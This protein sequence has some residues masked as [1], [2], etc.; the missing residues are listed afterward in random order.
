MAI[1]FFTLIFKK[2]VDGNVFN[3][4]VNVAHMKQS[5]IRENND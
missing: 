4:A 2:T 5:E 1:V 3:R